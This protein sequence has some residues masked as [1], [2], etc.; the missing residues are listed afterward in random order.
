MSLSYIIFPEVIAFAAMAVVILGDTFSNVGGRFFGK[1]KLGKRT[2]EGAI[3]GFI[4]ALL[5]TTR[6]RVTMKYNSAATS[7]ET[8][9]YGEVEDYTVNVTGTASTFASG[10]QDTEVLGNEMPTEIAVYPNPAIS[11]VMVDVLNGS[12]VGT[13]SIYNMIGSLMKVVEINGFEKEVNISDLPSGSYIISVEDE[14]G[15]VVKQFIK[16]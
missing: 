10:Y 3:I 2:V 7:C 5:G 9:T 13:I 4:F 1:I 12:K 11:Y 8:F 14:K 6:M 15:P 16:E